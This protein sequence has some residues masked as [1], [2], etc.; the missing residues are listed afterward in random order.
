MKKIYKSIL[1]TL[2]ASVAVTSCDS[3]EAPNLHT[4]PAVTIVGRD[5]DFPAAAS[6]GTI[7]FEADGPVT[8]TSASEWITATVEGDEIHVSCTQN[9]SLE[10]R[11][12]ILT[13]KCDDST[14]E[15]AIIQEG[16]IF[17]LSDE[18]DLTF[19]AETGSKTI[20]TKSNI[21]LEVRTDSEWVTA[22][23]DEGIITV[24]VG[25]NPTLDERNAKLTVV[26]GDNES[27]IG[28]KQDGIYF[29]IFD[30][31][32]WF[33]NDSKNRYNYDFPFDI[34]VKYTSTDPEWLTYEQ[35]LETKKLYF[36][37]EK[38]TTG[39]V[40][41]GSFTYEI[42]PK[43]G[44]MFVHQC[45]F[46]K[47]LASDD[48]ALYF[49]DP[50][51]GKLYYVAV[52]VKQEGT[53]HFIELPNDGI[54][55]PFTYNT[56]N[57]TFTIEGGQ[58]CGIWNNRYYIF[59]TFGFTEDGE[60]YY[61]WAAGPSIKALP[62]YEFDAES[63]VGY[64]AVEFEDAGTFDAP[65]DYFQLF[66]FSSDKPSSNT[67]AGYLYRMVNPFLMRIHPATG[68]APSAA[69][70]KAPRAGMARTRTIDVRSAEPAQAMAITADSALPY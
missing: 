56:S 34:T 21:P 10:S 20:A 13:V 11:S 44:T 47:D 8:V 66:A 22:S 32:E 67:S 9:N 15:I 41:T 57:H 24:T 36:N 23:Y 49:T 19:K 12:G 3:Y 40:R 62:Y 64:T 14:T 50:K 18:G 5:T 26:Y 2:L 33:V 25:Q 16:V 54:A 38:N 51:D 59:T 58:N 31:T 39:H 4:D 42:G 1:F 68:E 48:Y 37:V 63:N 28:V 46:A 43:S 65:L 35:N 53:N 27:T 6:T 29:S 52:I 70:A 69:P 45:D 55:I 7:K 30:R 60:G 17:Q 61:T